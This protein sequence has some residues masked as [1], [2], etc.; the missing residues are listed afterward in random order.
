MDAAK[1]LILWTE[2]GQPKQGTLKVFPTVALSKWQREVN[3]MT[4]LQGQGQVGECK[5]I[6]RCLW[7]S[8]TNIYENILRVYSPSSAGRY[9]TIPNSSSLIGPLQVNSSFLIGYCLFSV[10]CSILCLE[11]D[12]NET[13][14]QFLNVSRPPEHQ[15]QKIALDITAGLEYIHQHN[16]VH[17]GLTTTTI[18]VSS[19]TN[20]N[21]SSI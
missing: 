12:S 17:N 21:V 18:Y 14:K 3:A 19:S 11:H 4:K 5:N 20:S 2:N 8:Q 16:I 6:V 13:L 15:M 9:E 10:V 7:A 1:Y